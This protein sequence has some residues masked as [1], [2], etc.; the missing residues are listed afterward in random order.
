MHTLE[1]TPKVYLEWH[2][3]SNKIFLFIEHIN[4]VRENLQRE[5]NFKVLK[6]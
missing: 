4:N 1:A 2:S 6:V 3:Q 5:Y